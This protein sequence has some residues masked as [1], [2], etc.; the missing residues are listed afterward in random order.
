MV[1]SPDE[2]H[3][4]G[5]VGELGFPPGA[6]HDNGLEVP[7]VVSRRHDVRGRRRGEPLVPQ[8]LPSMRGVPTPQAAAR[9]ALA[10]RRVRAGETAAPRSPR[11]WMPA[12]ADVVCAAACGVSVSDTKR[13]Q[14]RRPGQ[15]HIRASAS[16]ARKTAI[17]RLIPGAR[18]E[19][20][21][22]HVAVGGPPKS[23]GFDS[24]QGK[25]GRRCRV[26]TYDERPIRPN[27]SLSMSPQTAKV[28]P[29]RVRLLPAIS[30]GAL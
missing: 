9:C 8:P 21:V 22:T 17:I 13:S 19:A 2:G 1:S 24:L 10:R 27:A 30:R 25:E 28:A 11:W 12:M 23:S 5:D 6:R 4:R 20:S 7:D 3:G 15:Q 14:L 29:N 16:T 18:L 26:A